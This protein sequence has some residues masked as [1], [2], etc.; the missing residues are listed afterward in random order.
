MKRALL[1]AEGIPFDHAG[2]AALAD[3][4]YSSINR[5]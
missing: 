5:R 3:F 4:F 2:R 1:A